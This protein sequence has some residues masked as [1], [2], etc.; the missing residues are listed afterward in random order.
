MRISDAKM[1]C[2]GP[3]QHLEKSVLNFQPAEFLELIDKAGL[4][5]VRVTF[6]NFG[7]P[8]RAPRSPA[9]PRCS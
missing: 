8:P 2:Y 3:W 6:M 5:L 4:D 7:I 9:C 1:L